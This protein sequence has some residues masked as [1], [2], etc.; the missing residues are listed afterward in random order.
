MQGEECREVRGA[1]LRPELTEHSNRVHTDR[2]SQGGENADR[3]GAVSG[4]SVGGLA[5]KAAPRVRAN[6]AAKRYWRAG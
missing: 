2:L 6:Q 3:K 4:Y 5:V 1:G